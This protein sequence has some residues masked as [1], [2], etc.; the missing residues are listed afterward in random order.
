MRTTPGRRTEMHFCAVSCLTEIASC[1]DL[2]IR[3]SSGARIRR[4]RATNS[5]S[6]DPQCNWFPGISDRW[7]HWPRSTERRLSLI[8]FTWITQTPSHC[9][10]MP[11][12]CLFLLLF[13]SVCLCLS[14]SVSVYLFVYLSASVSV[15]FCLPPNVSFCLCAYACMPL[16]VSVCICLSLF[17]SLCFCISFF[18]TVCLCLIRSASVLLCMSLSAYICLCLHLSLFLSPLLS[19]ILTLS[20]SHFLLPPL[21]P[22]S[23]IRSFSCY[24]TASEFFFIDS[25]NVF[26]KFT[27]KTTTRWSEN[28]GE[29]R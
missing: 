7:C 23:P 19:L 16:S 1:W 5:V 28:R 17:A 22:F 27:T 4:Q 13:V 21:P 18:V 9:V 25:H 10:V 3:F 24:L 14:L 26:E 11:S 6:E 8:V 2:E 20:S 15:C 29:G 12:V